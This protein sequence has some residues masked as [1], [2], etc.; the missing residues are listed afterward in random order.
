MKKKLTQLNINKCLSSTKGVPL[1][2]IYSQNSIVAG[3]LYLLYLSI[4]HKANEKSAN[5]LRKLKFNIHML[6]FTK[7]LAFFKVTPA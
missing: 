5:I 7:I 1:G 4:Q 3:F 2:S 6:I